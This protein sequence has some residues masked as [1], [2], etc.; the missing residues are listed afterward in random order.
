MSKKH[1]QYQAIHETNSAKKTTSRLKYFMFAALSLLV[2]SRR[3]FLLAKDKFFGTKKES[4]SIVQ[5]AQLQ[6]SLF[7]SFSIA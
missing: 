6:E 3:V 7:R 4:P 2:Y 5:Q 1:K